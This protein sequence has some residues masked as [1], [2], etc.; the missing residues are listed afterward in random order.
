MYI[1]EETVTTIVDKDGRL[2][3]R[4]KSRY[5]NENTGEYISKRD[6]DTRKY[7]DA[8]FGGSLDK[9]FEAYNDYMRTK[10]W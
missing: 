1:Y 4:V 8:T 5:V 10:E 6:R 2:I 3:E 9:I 7:S